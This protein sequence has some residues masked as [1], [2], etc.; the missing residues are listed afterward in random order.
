MYKNNRI[1]STKC[2]YQIDN[3]KLTWWINEK[4]KLNS[5]INE[6][7]NINVTINTWIPWNSVDKKKLIHKF[8]HTIYYTKRSIFIFN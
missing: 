5:R 1:T 4:Y 2:Q 8:Y 6:I 3:S 7:I